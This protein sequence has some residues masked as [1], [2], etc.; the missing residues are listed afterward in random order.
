MLDFVVPIEWNTD[1]NKYTLPNNNWKYMS[2]LKKKRTWQ[3]VSHLQ[4]SSN[5]IIVIVVLIEVTL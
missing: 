2:V 4:C 1:Y 5:N 3:W